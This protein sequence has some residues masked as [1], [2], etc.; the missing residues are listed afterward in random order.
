MAALPH[1]LN[2]VLVLDIVGLL[3]SSG[4]IHDVF[5]YIVPVFLSDWEY[6]NVTRIYMLLPCTHLTQGVRI[7]ENHNL[8]RALTSR[9]M[10]TI[11][12]FTFEGNRF[13]S[14]IRD[15]YVRYQATL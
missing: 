13:T 8:R 11:P 6:N 10:S 9:G 4:V 2:G 7:M 3:A 5:R 14:T 1:G 15:R 12:W